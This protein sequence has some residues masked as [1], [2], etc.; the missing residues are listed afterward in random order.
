M[1]VATRTKA[2]RREAGSAPLDN[3]SVAKA[4]EGV[5]ELL[6]QQGA[7]LYRVNAY[8]RGADVV[9]G[10]S[11]PAHALLAREGR[12]GLK[13]LPGIGESLSAAIEELVTTGRL[14]L[15]ERLAGHGEQDAQGERKATRT[16]G[17][18]GKGRAPA[19]PPVAELLDVDVE[20]RARAM[21]GT[22]ARIAPKKFNPRNEAWLPVL[23]TRRHGRNYTALYSNTARA[24]ELGK[25]RDWVVIYLEDDDGGGQW[26]VVTEHRGPLA[27]RRVVRGREGE[28]AGR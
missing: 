12:A 24:H 1:V 10:L 2:K 20:Y 21:A 23:H 13:A 14:D 15:H 5:A 16:R 17:A 7:N 9:R 18:R 3:E 19:E 11:E 27:G 4:L 28:C 6:A 26:T 25:T 22:I 8:F